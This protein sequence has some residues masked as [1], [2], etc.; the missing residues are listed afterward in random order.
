MREYKPNEKGESGW[1]T[2]ENPLEF[3]YRQLHIILILHYQPTEK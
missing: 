2:D 3:L 1:I